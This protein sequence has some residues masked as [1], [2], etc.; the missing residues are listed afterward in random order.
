MVMS[1]LRMASLHCC[2]SMLAALFS[3]TTYLTRLGCNILNLQARMA[4]QSYPYR[5]GF[6]RP[7]QSKRAIKAFMS[8]SNSFSAMPGSLGTSTSHPRAA[9]ASQRPCSTDGSALRPVRATTT[10]S[11]V[12]VQ[13][14][15][16]SMGPVGRSTVAWPSVRLNAL[17][18]SA[19]F[20]PSA[21]ALSFASF[22]STLFFTC[23]ACIAKRK[24]LTLSLMESTAC[25]TQ[26]MRAVLLLPPSPAFKMLVKGD[27]L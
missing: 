4:P 10:F 13:R 25:V 22:F 11:P 7:S 20:C 9:S 15:K 1:P 8:V 16:T 21:A 2:G 6:E 5:T 26:A 24:V 17:P 14:P 23:E 19:I 18:L 3:S 12:P 27:A